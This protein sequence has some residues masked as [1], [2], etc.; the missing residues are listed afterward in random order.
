ME[1]V[2]RIHQGCM[3]YP[4]L[5]VR[6]FINDINLCER[7]CLTYPRLYVRALL[8]DVNLCGKGQIKSPLN[9]LCLDWEG[10]NTT[11]NEGQKVYSWQA[12]EKSGF[13]WRPGTSLVSGG[14]WAQV[15]RRVDAERKSSVGRRQGKYPTVVEEESGGKRALFILLL[16]SSS[17][18]L[19]SNASISDQAKIRQQL[20][21]R[22]KFGSTAF[23]SCLLFEIKNALGV[24]TRALQHV[25]T[26]K[27]LWFAW[28]RT[29]GG[30]PAGMVETDGDQP[31]AP[32]RR[33]KAR[34]L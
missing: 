14:R 21:A 33:T 31:T 12:T 3:T 6:S 30:K 24:Q 23:F 20:V 32:Q 4:K 28:L 8:D 11:C 9:R 17:L 18:L 7:G 5:Y 29:D 19:F 15:R 10:A 25:Q 2:M 1:E 34:R 13:T 16:D 22:E 26:A 27:A